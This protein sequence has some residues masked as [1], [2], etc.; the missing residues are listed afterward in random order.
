M[1]HSDAKRALINI[2]SNTLKPYFAYAMQDVVVLINLMNKTEAVD[3]FVETARMLNMS[4]YDIFGRST[5]GNIVNYVCNYASTE[6]NILFPANYQKKQKLDYDGAYN[7]VDRSGDVYTNAAV[8][9]FCSA[10]PSLIIAHNLSPET[11]VS[12]TKEPIDSDTI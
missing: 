10:Y 5:T 11:I 9:D 3:Q 12:V 4:I 7:Y 6:S 8:Y 1:D 2:D